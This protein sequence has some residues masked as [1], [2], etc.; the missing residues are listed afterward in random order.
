[1][2]NKVQGWSQ[3]GEFL[4]GSMDFWTLVLAGIDITPT[5]VTGDAADVNPAGV[6]PIVVNGVSYANSTD[7]NTARAKQVNFDKVIAVIS[8]RA[9]PVILGAVAFSTN[10]TLKFA[11]EHPEAWTKASLEAALTAAGY[12]PTATLA[13]VL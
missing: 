13:T 11:I 1:M 7:Y 6:Y 12:T 8:T 5:G 9:Q 3:P 4:V 10:S 2:V